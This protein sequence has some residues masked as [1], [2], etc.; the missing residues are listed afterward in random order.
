MVETVNEGI[1]K[2]E[3]LG[4]GREFVVSDRLKPEQKA[5]V[6][7]A[8]SSRDLVYEISGAAGVGKTTL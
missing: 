1:G 7:S 6:L 8:L 4:R 5:A 3:A 2:Y